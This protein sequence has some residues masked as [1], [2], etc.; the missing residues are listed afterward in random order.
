MRGEAVAKL[1][2]LVTRRVRERSEVNVQEPEESEVGVLVTAVRRRR[3]HHQVARLLA[4]ESLQQLVALMAPLAGRR[5]GMRLV[6]DDQLGA[7]A[8][9]LRA[10]TLALDVVEADDRM[11]VRREDT[12]ARREVALEAGGTRRC[13]RDGPEVETPLE[14]GH[15]LVHEVR[16]AEHREALDVA[17][18][19]QFARDER[20]LDGL[21]DA[22]VVGD[23]QPDRI[24]L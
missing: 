8:K 5:T 1:L 15:P 12:L 6:D 7:C 4:D 17:A 9:E 10:T 13:D 19:E 21:A 11:R 14:L 3:E 2:V 23:E 16:R 24:E 18:V 22:D 20:G